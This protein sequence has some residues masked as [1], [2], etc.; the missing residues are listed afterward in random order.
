MS[1]YRRL[2]AIAGEEYS[3][4]LTQKFSD[5]P[6][7]FTGAINRSSEDMVVR[8]VAAINE[9]E[10][11]DDALRRLPNLEH[12]EILKRKYCSLTPEKDYAIYTDFSWG[13]DTYYIELKRAL[14]EFSETYRNGALLVFDE[15]DEDFLFGWKV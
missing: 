6:R 11:I 13:E 1:G 9:L 3:P 7:A 10:H 2:L 12:I 8:K 4:K 15:E 5:E 14:M